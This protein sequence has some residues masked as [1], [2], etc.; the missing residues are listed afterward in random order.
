MAM[1][2]WIT[3]VIIIKLQIYTYDIYGLVKLPQFLQ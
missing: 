3:V 2:G 1:K